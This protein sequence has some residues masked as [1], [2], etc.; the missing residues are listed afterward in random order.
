MKKVSLP[1]VVVPDETEELIDNEGNTHKKIIKKKVIKKRKGGKQENTIITSTQVN[2]EKPIVTVDVQTG[3]PVAHEDHLPSI[4]SSEI[5]EELPEEITISEVIDESGLPKKKVTKK[6]VLKTRKGDKVE[7]TEL[8]TVEEVGKKPENT[9]TIEV[10]D[11]TPEIALPSVV[12]ELPDETQELIDNEGNVHMKIIR[13]KVIKKRKGDKQENTIITSTQVDDEKPI[14]TVDI[15]TDQPVAHEE[16]LPSLFIS[17]I[18]EELPEEII[19]SEVIDESGQPKKKV[20]KKK[21]LKTRKGDKVEKTEVISV[22]EVGKKPENTVTIE[23]VDFVP[24]VA[25]TP[26]VQELPDETEELIDNEGNVDDERPIVTV[27]VQTNQPVPHEEPLLSIVSSEIVEEHPEEI[28]ISEV[29]D[30]SGLPKKK[31]TRKKVLKTRKGDKVEKTESVEEVGTKPEN[32]VT[33]E[34]VDFAPEIALPSVVQELPEETEEHID[35][36]GNVHKKIIKKKVIKKRKGDKQE[37]TIIT[38]TQVDDEKP[39]LTVDVQTD[40]PLTREESLPSLVSSEIVEELPEEITISE[41]IDE[42]GLPMKKVTKKRVL[43]TRRGDKVER[44]ELISVE[45]V[46]KKPENTVTIEIVEFTPEEALPSVVQELP[47]ESDELIDNEGNIHKKIIKKKVDDEKPIVTVDVQTDQPLAH[48]EPLPSIVSSEIFEELPEEITISEVIDESGLPKRKVTKKKVLK[49]RKGDKVEKTEVISVEEVGKKPENTV[50]IE[51]VDFTPEIALPSV[52]E[53]LP[54]ET[55]ELIDNEGNVHKK[56]IKKKVIKKRKGD[57]Q[58]NTIITSTQV[59]DEKPILT[60]DVQTDQPVTREESLPSLVTS[61]IVEELPEEITIS[62]VID[63]SGLPKTKVTKKKVL[64]TRKGDKVEKTEVISV[65]EVGKKPENTVTIEVV[66]FTPEIALPSVIEELPDET[67]ELI[68]NEGNVHKKIIKKKVIKKRKGDKQENTI[69]TSTQVDEGKPILTVDVQ[70]DQPLTREESLPSLVSSEVVEELPEEITISEVID[71]SGVPKKKVTKKRVLKTRKGDKVE[72]TEFISVEEVGKKPENTVTIEIVEFTPEEAL[73]SVV[74]ELPDE[75][76]ELIDN[77]GNIHKKIIKKKVI[78][79]RKGDKQENTVI[80]ST[81]VDDEKPIVTVDVQTDQP[82]AHEEPLPSIVSSEIFEELPEEITISEVIDESGL[83]KRKVTK[84]KV[85]KTR[86]GDKVEKTEVISVEEVGKKPENTVTIEVVDFTPEIA[87]PSVIE[88]LPDETEELIDNEGNVHK[89][90]IKK[91][92]IKKRKGDKQ[93]NTIITSTQVDDEKPILTV[94]VQTDQPVTREESLPSLVTSEIVEELPEEI[95]IS[96]VIDESGLPKTKVTKKKVLKTRKGD[97]VEK[98]EVISVEEVGKKPENTV[99]IE[100]VDFTPEI[101]LP[102]VI[103]ELPDE[104]EELIDNEG[105]VHKKIIKKK[106]IKNRKGEK[107]ENTIITSTQVDDEKPIVTVDVQT[108]QPLTREESLPSLVSSEVVEELPEEITISEVIDESGLPKK[109]VTKKKVL[110]TRKGDKVEK[111]EVI[112]VEE[113][114][115]KPESTVTIEVV[116]FT[117]EI[118]LPSVVQEL[119]DETEELIDNEGNVH[120]KIIKKKV[121]KKRK[122]DKQENTII[123]STQVDEGKPILTVDVQTD[124]PLTREESLPSLVSSE[125]V[126]ELPEEITISEVIDESGVPKKKVTKKRVLK[127]RKG[128]KVERTEFISVEEVGKKP[129]NTV[130]IEVVDFTPEVALPSVVRELPDKTEEFTDNEGNVHKKIIKK[131]VIKKRKGDKQENTVITSTQVDDEKPIVTVDVQTDQPLAHEEYLPSLDSSEIV[132]EL[133]EEITISEVIDES[134]LPKKK[135]TKKKVLK[136]RRGDKVERTELISVEEVGKKPENTVT[137]EIVEFTPEVALPS[138]VQELPDESEE[139]IDNEG[140]I[141]KKIIKKKVIKKRKGDKQENT[142]ITSTQIDDEKPIVTVDVQ[143]DQPVAHE[144][145]LPSKVSSEIFEEIPEEITISEVIDESGLPKKKVTKKK[146]LK[147]RKGDKVE[148]TEV[149]SVE[150]VGKKP[151]NTVTI[152]VVDFT[153]EEALPSVVQELPDETEELI[154]NEGNVHKKIIKKKVIKKRKGDRQENTIITSTQV[155]EGKAILTVDVQTDQPLTREE[156]LPSLVSSEIVEELPEEI[157]ISE[158]IDESGL[159]KKKVT[160]KRV[161][162]TRRGDKVERTELISV[163]EVGK[164]PENTV[165]IEI[166]EF[167]PEVALPS[168]VQELPDESEELI[169]NEGNVHKKI[170]KKKVIK[171]RKGDEQE[172]TIITSTQVDD[173]KPTL[174]VDVQT[175]QPLTREESL[176][177]LVSSEVVEELPEEITISEVIDE[178][179]LPKKKVTKKKVLKTRKGDKVEKTEVISVEEVGKKPENTV[180]DEKPILTVDV[181]TDQP[182]AHEESLPSLVSSEIVE[183]LPEEITISEVI[184]ESGLPKKKVTKKRVLKTRRGDKVER[185]ELISVEEVGK[186]PENTVTIEIVEFTPEVALPSV[187]QELPDES[188]EFIDNEGNV[189]K[190]IIKKKVIKKRK[191][192]KQENTI[193]TSTQVD[194]EKP[195]LTVDVQTNQPLT[196]EESL[197]SL[198][199]SEVV[200][201]LPEEITISEVI[202]ESGLPKKKVTKKKVLKTRK[203]DKVEKTEVISVEEVGKKPESTVTIE[204]VDFTP[205]I[206]LPSVV[207]ELPDETEELIDNEGNVHKKI[208]KKKVIK[209]RK[210]DKQEYTI[211]TSTQVDDEKP[212]LTVDVQTDQPLA[213]EESLPSLVSSEVVEELPDEITI[214]EVIDESGV[215]KKKVTKKRV[216]KTRKGDK[217]ERTEFISVEEVGKKPENTVTIEVVD[218]TPEVALPSVVRE[219]PDKTEEFTDNEGNVHK[220]IIK[221]KVIKKRKGDKQENTV[222]TSTQVDDEKP[223]LTVDVQTDQPLTREESLPS[224]VSSEIVEELPEEITISEVIDESGLPKKKVTKKNVLKTREGD[225]VEKTEMISVEEVGKK[226]ENTVTIEVVD[227]TPEIAL[228]S[229]VQELQDETE[230]LIDNEGNVHKKIIKKKVI[231]KRKGDKQ[232]NTIIT[233]TQVDDEK[234]TL[235][236]DVQT[237]QPLTREESLPSLVSSEIVEELPEEI[238]ISEVIDESGLPK[239]KELP[240]ESEELIDN[241]GNIHKKIIKKKVIKKR[242]GDKQENTI[243]TS[244]Q[245]DDEKPIVTVDVQTD[246]PVAHEEPLP[247]IVS[248]EVVE[249]LPEEI[250]ISEI[251]D[252][253]G[254]P[255][256]KV[257]KKKVLKTPKG[258][259]VEKTEVISVEEVGK[260]PENTVTIEVVDFTPEIALPSVVQEFPDETEKLIDNEGNVHKKIIKKKVIKKRKG[261]KQ[262]NTIITSTQVDDEKPIVTVDVQADQPVAHDE[263]LPSIVSSEIV[264][265]LPEEITISEVIDECGL[266]KKKVT[267]KKVL[268]TRKGDKVEKTEVISVEEVGKKPENT[269]TIEIVEFTPEVAVTSVVQEI[270]DESEKLIDNEG[271]VHKKII[272]KKVI[273]KRIGDKQENTIITSTQVD[274]EKPILTVDVQTDQPVAHEEPLPSI[275]SSEIVDELPEEITISEVIDESG[276]PK[277]KVTKKKVLKTPKGDK[278]EKTEVISVEEV[279]KKPENTVTIEVVDFTPEIA[280][281]SVVQELPDET[282]ELVDNEGNVHKKIIKK[283]V[284]KKRKGDKQENTI[285]TST[286]VDDEKPILTVDVQT[287]HLLTREESLPSLVSSEVFEELPEEITI[288]EVIDE[289]GVPKKKVTKKRVLKTRKGDKVERTEFISVEEVG[290]KPE[291]T[292]TIEVVDFTP[293]VAL[294]SVVQE[295]PD[296]TE[297]LVDSEGIVH[298][299][300]IKKKV[301]KKRKGDKQENTVITSTQVDDEKPIVTV[302]VQTDQPLAHEESLP[303]LVSSEIVE[304]LPEEITISEV[305]DESGV[306]KKKVTKKRVLKT[307]KGDKVERTEF[308][309][310]EEVGKKPENTVSIEVVDFTPEVALPSVVQELPDETEELI[311]SEGIVHKKIIKKKVIKKRKGDKQENTVITSTQVDDEKPIVTVDVQT[312]QPLAHEESLPS[313]VSSEI[314]EELP[315][316]ITISEV[317][318]ESGVPKKKVTKKR[319]LK[320]RKGDKVERTEFISVEEVGKKPESTVT[321]EVV[322]FTPEVALPSVVQELPDETEELIDS[323]GIVHKKIIKKKV[324]KKRKGD[325]QE[326]TVI[327]STQ[328]DDEKPIVTVDVQTDQPLAHEESL[329]SLDSSEIVEELPEEI[330]ISEVIDESGLPKKKVT[331]KRV[332]KTR[333]GDKVERTELISVEEVGK[334]PENTVTIE[335][336]EFTPEI[337]LPSVVQELP[338]EFEELM[339][340][341]GNIHKKIIKKKVIKKRKGDKQ[342]NTII[343]ST[344]VDDEKPIVTVDVQTDQPVAHEEPLPSIVSSEIFEE[345]PEEI[346]ISEVIDESGLPKKKVTKKKV[347]ET[348][349]G[350]KVEKTEVIS[351]EEVGKKPEN[352]VTIEADEF[353]PEVAL[354]SVVQ[355]LSDESEELV[356]NE[357]NIHKKIIKKKIIEKR[358]GDK[359]E[360]TIITSTQVDEEK[361]IVTVDIQTDQ[362]VAHEKS[363]PLISSEIYISESEIPHRFASSEINEKLPSVF[364]EELDEILSDIPNRIES[365]HTNNTLTTSFTTEDHS[366]DT[367]KDQFEDI[368]PSNFSEDSNDIPHSEDFRSDSMKDDEIL[369]PEVVDDLEV[370]FSNRRKKLI[371]KKTSTAIASTEEPL[372]EA[373][374]E[375]NILFVPTLANKESPTNTKE[376]I[377]LIEVE[378]LKKALSHTIPD[379]IEK[380]E[381]KPEETKL[382]L[383]AVDVEPPQLENIETPAEKTKS[384]KTIRKKITKKTK[385]VD[386]NVVPLARS[387]EQLLDSPKIKMDMSD[388]DTSEENRIIPCS[389]AQIEDLPKESPIIE[390]NEHSE[391]ERMVK[392]KKSPSE[393]CSFTTNEDLTLKPQEVLLDID[394]AYGVEKTPNLTEKIEGTSDENVIFQQV[395]P[396]DVSPDLDMGS[397]EKVQE[398]LIGDQTKSENIEFPELLEF[399]ETAAPKPKSSVKK[400]RLLKP[401]LKFQ[402]ILLK[403]RIKFVDFPP[404]PERPQP[405]ILKVLEPLVKN[406]GT[407]SRNIKE[408]MKIPKTLPRKLA[409]IDDDLKNLENLDKEFEKLKKADL[410]KVNEEYRKPIAKKKPV[411]K[412][413]LK[414]LE[415]GQ[416]KQLSSEEIEEKPQLR[417][418]PLF[419]DKNAYDSISE[420][421]FTPKYSE[422]IEFTIVPQETHQEVKPELNSENQMDTGLTQEKESIYQPNE[423]VKG[424]KLEIKSKQKSPEF[425]QEKKDIVENIITENQS[426]KDDIYPTDKKGKLTGKIPKKS[427]ISLKPIET[428]KATNEKETITEMIIEKPLLMGS[429]VSIPRNELALDNLCLDMPQEEPNKNILP[430]RYIPTDKSENKDDLPKKEDKEII[431]SGYEVMSEPSDE[432]LRG[433][434]VGKV[435]EKIIEIPHLQKQK[436]TLVISNTSPQFA[437][438]KETKEE[439]LNLAKTNLKKIKPT[440]KINASPSKVSKVRLKSRIKF[441]EFPPESEKEQFIFSTILKPVYSG[442]GTLSRNIDEAIKI[443]KKAP[444]ND[445]ESDLK[446][447]DRLNR[448]H[449]EGIGK[450]EKVD[451]EFKLKKKPKKTEKVKKLTEKENQIMK[452]DTVEMED[453]PLFQKIETPEQ[454]TGKI[455]EADIKKEMP[456]EFEKKPEENTSPTP[457]QTPDDFNLDNDKIKKKPKM[458]KGKTGKVEGEILEPNTSIVT[459]DESPPTV[460]CEIAGEDIPV[461]ANIEALEDE[462]PVSNYEVE[463]ISSKILEEPKLQISTSRKPKDKISTIKK[464]KIPRLKSRISYIE[465]PP[466]SQKEKIPIIK[467]L[468]PVVKHNGV[469]SRTMTDAKKL[470]KKKKKPNTEENFDKLKELDQEMEKLK[471]EKLDEIDEEYRKQPKKQ[472]TKSSLPKPTKIEWKSLSPSKVKISDITVEPINLANIKLKKPRIPEQKKVKPIEKPRIL[473]KSRIILIEFPPFSEKEK[474]PCI[475]ELKKVKIQNGTYSHNIQDAIIALK[476]KKRKLLDKGKE[477]PNLEELDSEIEEAKKKD[478]E[479][480]DEIYHTFKKKPKEKMTESGETPITL[481]IGKGKIPDKPEE[482]DETVTLKKISKETQ[483]HTVAEESLPKPQKADVITIPEKSISES[484]ELAPLDDF[485]CEHERPDLEIYVPSKPDSSEEDDNGE[486]GTKYERKQKKKPSP[487]IIQIP[488]EKGVPIISE[489]S[490][491]NE[492]KFRKPT[493]DI[494]DDESSEITLKP[495][496]KSKDDIKESFT[497]LEIEKPQDVKAVEVKSQIDIDVDMGLAKKKIKKKLKPKQETPEIIE[498][499][500]QEV[501]V[502]SLPEIQPKT[503]EEIVN[504]I[505]EPITTIEEATVDNKKEKVHTLEEPMKPELKKEKSEIIESEYEVQLKKPTSPLKQDEDSIETQFIISKPFHDK[506]ENAPE[507]VS[508]TISPET[509]PKKSEESI[510]L[511]IKETIFLEEA[512]I[513]DKETVADSL[514][515]PMPS[516]ESKE[517]IPETI[518]NEYKVKPLVPTSP[519]Q[520]EEQTLPKSSLGST[521][522]LPVIISPQI[523]SEKPE[524]SVEVILKPKKSR[525]ETIENEYEFK[526]KKSIPKQQQEDIQAQITIPKKIDKISDIAADDYTVTISPQIKPRKSE[527]SANLIIEQ[528]IDYK[529]EVLVDDI[530]DIPEELTR[531]DDKIPES[532]IVVGREPNILST[533]KKDDNVEEGISIAPTNE[534]EDNIQLIDKRKKPME[535]KPDDEKFTVEEISDIK[536]ELITENTTQ[537]LASKKKPVD[538]DHQISSTDENEIQVTLKKSKSKPVKLKDVEEE[539]QFTLPKKEENDTEDIFMDIKLNSGP[540]DKYQDS[541]ETLSETIKIPEKALIYEDEIVEETVPHKSINSVDEIQQ[542]VI[543]EMGEEKPVADITESPSS[544]NLKKEEIE[545]VK[546]ILPKLAESVPLK[547]EED[548]VEN[549]LIRKRLPKN[550]IIQEESDTNKVTLLLSKSKDSTEIENAEGE[551]SIKVIKKKIKSV[552]ESNDEINIKLVESD[553][554]EN[555]I[556]DITEEKPPTKKIK[557]KKQVVPKKVEEQV[558]PVSEL[559]PDDS[560]ASESL[561]LPEMKEDTDK[562]SKVDELREDIEN[563]GEFTLRKQRKKDDEDA[564]ETEI[565]IPSRKKIEE[566]HEFTIK[567]KPARKP[568]IE[569]YSEDITIKKLRKIRKPSRPDIPEYTDVT[570][571]TFRPKTTKTKEDVDQEFKISL[572]SYAEEEISMSGKVRLKKKRPSTYSEEEGQETIRIFKE[573]EDLEGPTI[574]EIIDEGSDAEE[575]PYDEESPENFHVPLKRKIPRKYSVYEEDEESIS[576]GLKRTK[577]HEDND[578]ESVTLR[579]K[580]KPSL[581]Y[582][583]EAASLS[584]TKRTEVDEEEQP[585]LEIVEGDTVYCICVYNSETDSVIDLVEGE[586]LN[587][588]E[589][590]DSNWWFVKK[591]TTNEKGW[592]PSKLLMDETHYKIYVQKKLNEK[593]DQLPVFEK[594]SGKQKSVA[595]K[596]LEKIKPVSAKDGDTVQFQCQV[597]GIPRPQITWFRQTAIIKHSEDFE[598]Y[599]DEE[600]VCTLI[601]KEVFPE[602]AGLITCVAKNSSGFASTSTELR[603]ERTISE[604]YSDFTHTTRKSM[605]KESSFVDNLDGIPPTFFHKPN[606]QCV[607][608]DADVIVECGLVAL[609]EPH[610]IWYSKGRIL[611]SHNNITVE[612]TSENHKYRTCLKI[613]NIEKVQEGEYEIVARNS[614]G[615][616][617]IHFTIDVMS[618]REQPPRVIEPL[619]STTVRKRET[620]VLQTIIT[621]NPPANIEWFK[622]NEQIPQSLI[623]QN[624]YTYTYTIPKA[625]LGDAG[626]YLVRAT[627]PCGTAETSAN[628]TVEEYTVNEVPLFLERFEAVAV[629]VKTTIRLTARVTGNPIPEIIWLKNNEPLTPREE[630]TTSFDGEN[631]ELVIENA[632]SEVDSGDYKCIARNKVG[633]ASHGAKVTVEVDEIRFTKILNKSYES[634]E[635][636]T[637]ELICETSHKVSTKWFFN[638]TEISGMDHRIV[639]EEGKTHKLIIKNVTEKDRGHYKCTVKNVS[640]ETTVTV[641]PT[642]PEFVRRLQDLEIPER[643]MAILEVEI[644]S[645]TADVMW[646]KD[647]EIIRESKNVEFVKEGGVRKLLIRSISIHDEGEYTCN[648]EDEECK[649]E[650][651]IIE[652]PPEIISPLQDKTVNRGEKTIFEIELSKGDAL[653]KWFKDGI[654][655]QFSEHIQLSIDGKRQKLKIYNSEMVDAGIYTCEIGSQKSSAQLTVNDGAVFF[656]R[657]LPEITSVPEETDAEFWVELSEMNVETEWMMNGKKIINSSKYEISVNKTIRKL[658]VRNITNEDESEYS[659]KITF[660]SEVITSST[661]LKVLGKPSP[662]RGP[663]Q[664][665]GMSYNS[666]TLHWEP[667]EYD[668]QSPIIEYIVEMKDVRHKEFKKVGATKSDCTNMPINYLEKDHGYKFRITARNSVGTSDPF[669]PEETIVAGSRITPPSPPINLQLRD[670][671]SRS[672]TLI[673]EPPENNGGTEITGYVVERKLEFMPKWEKVFTLEAFTLQYTFENLKEKSDY[674]FRVFAE[675]SIG[676]SVPTVTDVVQLKTHATVPSAPTAP[677]EI[678]TIGPN[679]IV[680]EWGLPETDGGSPLLGYKIAIKDTKKTMWMEI[681]RVNKGVHKFTIR[682]LQEGHDYLIRIFARNEI[683]LS[684]PLES[685]E[686]FKVLP[687]GETDQEDFREVTDKEPTSYSTETT[688][689]WLRENNMDADIYSYA[690]GKLLQRDEYFFRIWCY[691]KQLFK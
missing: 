443:K 127:T 526:L 150:E 503:P 119:P 12:Q 242:E 509:K 480:V 318:D 245:V 109:K 297:E 325:K 193:I 516:T 373:N 128:D 183:E 428:D 581:T 456:T 210:G 547:D 246:Q 522:E 140:N 529:E 236:V 60:V 460:I 633:E 493:K 126:E 77:E 199:S 263:P 63:E 605:S 575:L 213:R 19:I 265:E 277:K 296:E 573:V 414:T 36:E 622:N 616:S 674:R 688:T 5:V 133:P 427:D 271:N 462:G 580:K 14:V 253:S 632:N 117:P 380:E 262:E 151:E 298:K 49:T 637:L 51:V 441:I 472:I 83:P 352:T 655:I 72:R 152:E 523:E 488:I 391:I 114:G 682:D 103:E 654:E 636:E 120:K 498:S 664:I 429:E 320:T 650:L 450:L 377:K 546:S 153:P 417:Q 484:N 469:L 255:K 574:E 659:C 317:I 365:T 582:D 48:E 630:I 45:E 309:S 628:L 374:Q 415:T 254:L 341:E 579:P 613:K 419:T 512:A 675:N 146:V 403:S 66:D 576:I 608:R 96:E 196:R 248:S 687:S 666:F 52:I 221:K 629:P 594:P 393:K 544:S 476:K 672:A 571:V 453:Q 250:T 312:D 69:I 640:T 554:I 212:I 371:K 482:T 680:I 668:G 29:I 334:K 408:A 490:E 141:H 274:D 625:T 258:D 108:N 671:T 40:Q 147:T 260:K 670:V 686:P 651:N 337:A 455:F 407:L 211:I 50:T 475:A 422:T 161:L 555:S 646:Q 619:Y 542:E 495:F 432:K 533:D 381:S 225:K 53:E 376:V 653:A 123:T 85:L 54:D 201:E 600:N 649:A 590:D 402:K 31:V 567:K 568:S 348:R 94:D 683:G 145:P 232:E 404:L 237:D 350:D 305:I 165:T 324:I 171:K 514:Q 620:V 306:P 474:K 400:S 215:P 566:V 292:V 142:I 89:K 556:V 122:G 106:V 80:T 466:N 229:V 430:E 669:V 224:L 451:E 399:G 82:L 206:A 612:T 346:T 222:I 163:E 308:I 190:K 621:S 138:V 243:I 401:K 301:I 291:N 468:E 420:V 663:L 618:D 251:I 314:V 113:V 392:R 634:I 73:P 95:T 194:D 79:K 424:E 606:S 661:Q 20:T 406:T 689:S 13:K 68:D 379:V 285:I 617:R 207:Q 269:V 550:E 27:D 387:D 159:P 192:D 148:K 343:T 639:V 76:D 362:H 344:Q 409:P 41:V 91:K 9:V 485:S 11:F 131:K 102:S 67:E 137:I 289:S 16:P 481:T 356:D 136:T 170:I 157:T 444:I 353:T 386:D 446:E 685:D 184:D 491:E 604:H 339:D 528:K 315:E 220:K 459:T 611:K 657:K 319:V 638:N 418:K 288:S 569:E 326:N 497:V 543:K 75:S 57:K 121:I 238:T 329:P 84:K 626:E 644:S 501:P 2:D 366:L 166:V 667:S 178:S 549:V 525:P 364:N 678:R 116:D 635:R 596:F 384:S 532:L 327:T 233:S 382:K 665:S 383:T 342:E 280:L 690:R 603:V 209:K 259:K 648:L 660:R 363:S 358:K 175:N 156:S 273:K 168:V 541:S 357:G 182:L 64:K 247:S 513:E 561:V 44:T 412:K 88:E 313:L 423:E 204:V 338:D 46:G 290:K 223:I 527:E 586:K 181:Q 174:T 609:P 467:I 372:F 33:I 477:V 78:K 538:T 394:D 535:E 143:T 197:P 23:V 520:K 331:K 267:K 118:A 195:T 645:D 311:D 284:I 631:I 336:V 90:I 316:E 111:T 149:I 286:Q 662:P 135:V 437:V 413:E 270:P 565:T 599:Y 641:T 283:K 438:R 397:T 351:V 162:K 295:L 218:F 134:G 578:A 652:M 86:K 293:E 673:W 426:V 335:I 540:K 349:K 398:E 515:E 219:L 405:L 65:E 185:T 421:D 508:V 507:K 179:G 278:V 597:E 81:Q 656:K 191:G 478:L 139:L 93:E 158:V 252:E 266:P 548:K 132:E 524:E 25:F 330:T 58:E 144:E 588:I 228:P 591:Q 534:T 43:K 172:N 28:T 62:E 235:T 303:S 99:T 519:I 610:I 434:K 275:V 375:E 7:K 18:V 167:T 471:S 198:V 367:L 457:V 445:I 623:E 585:E 332:L 572:D 154:D 530:S 347:L 537:K 593:I 300:I 486:T 449:E 282:E 26:V 98:T 378:I 458:K 322:D 587:V 487:E 323:E 124:Q 436:A 176:P 518:A 425:I 679:A 276:L 70:T 627:N 658:I 32:T 389:K 577:Q 299:K 464:P 59:D 187:V 6:K 101:A 677:L 354:T 439:P 268:K 188:E 105:N 272:K 37:N 502:T 539:K 202:D 473:L 234:P 10:V 361:P 442:N 557:T 177:S 505:I 216:L 38:S 160:K 496:K 294:P 203:G 226:P 8:I 504:I 125:V 21:V 390:K 61:E 602:D 180:D 454:D 370:K 130:T 510:D 112:S 249:E 244:T 463:E 42:S 115:K 359:Q 589:A 517:E 239:K 200:E 261:D 230:E 30:E 241:E 35:N 1:S 483:E 155:D 369:T 304:E 186:K 564:V 395:S 560:R 447:L 24:E 448:E 97:K 333:R 240:D 624:E 264:E 531:L 601:I 388:Q 110:K 205:E 681:G 321:I 489:T 595:P 433:Q 511:I 257:T 499:D 584:I 189:H 360:N 56:I 385:N 558:S 435:E 47:D 431:E 559:V 281:P 340:N 607:Q 129:E 570:D 302:D 643:E 691:A 208:I 506:T 562:S 22:E 87:L 647:G 684:E 227:F 4:V 164:K 396:T 100:V 307:R 15:Q 217:V 107:Q 34:V 55:E 173:E 479:K 231:K 279:G 592:V 552:G 492:I 545:T 71:E 553:S 256:K 470:I 494:P 452:I 676:L 345:L 410:E 355:E 92:V 310:V 440:K 615:E 598:I 287:D 328:V 368:V 551:A 3:Q 583:Q 614:E 17:E 563:D 104:T 169:D 416:G 411:S 642:K 465:F 521:E 74:Q 461:L 39:I 214:S 536:Q 500:S